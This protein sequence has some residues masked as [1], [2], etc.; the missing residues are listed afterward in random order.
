MLTPSMDSPVPSS[1]PLGV[2]V[3]IPRLEAAWNVLQDNFAGKLSVAEL[4]HFFARVVL[5]LTTPFYGEG[6][7]S[8]HF[9]ICRDLVGQ[10][11]PPDRA[12]AA[13]HTVPDSD[14]TL[15]WVA[16]AYDA[17]ERQALRMGQALQKQIVNGDDLL[18]RPD[19][20]FEPV[21][22]KIEEELVDVGQG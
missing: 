13:L 9:E 6:P 22:G 20:A 2:D 4:D 7:P 5:G 1:E 8:L 3:F 18:A 21:G 12:Y 19:G 17:A 14:T 15:P 16:E 10:K 11:L